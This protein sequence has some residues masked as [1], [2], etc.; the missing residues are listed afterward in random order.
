MDVFVSEQDG[1]VVRTPPKDLRP[2][3]REALAA[4]STGLADAGTRGKLIMA[5][6]TGKTITSLRIAE[7]LVGVGHSVLY[8][9]PSLALMSQSVRE[10]AADAVV[11][12]RTF[13]V[14]SDAQVGR[15][16]KRDDDLIDM[17]VLD[18]AFPATTDA[19]R[20]AARAGVEACDEMT[21]VFATGSSSR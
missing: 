2:H 1:E 5:G 16:R 7:H 11:P 6:G 12:L 17:D 10:W 4:A 14:C 3:Q 18:L 9:V 21:V 19:A 15:R 8:L 20:L 13:A